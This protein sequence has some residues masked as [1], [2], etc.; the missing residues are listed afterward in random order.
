MTASR[1][2]GRLCASAVENSLKI[3]V[4]NCMDSG[5]ILIL[6]WLLLE[7]IRQAM[8]MST[9]RSRLVKGLELFPPHSLPSNTTESELVTR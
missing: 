2:D 9:I 5:L 4:Q 7:M 3:E 1:L 8:S 6:Q